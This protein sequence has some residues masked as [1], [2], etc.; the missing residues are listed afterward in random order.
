MPLILE[1]THEDNS[2]RRRR[3][4]AEIWR[5]GGREVSK[6]KIASLEFDPGDELADLDHHHNGFPHLPMEMTFRL[7]K[8]KKEKNPMQKAA[9]GKKQAGKAGKE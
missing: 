8:P 4:P 2:K 1:I 7:Q 3:R 9:E 6:Q 5:W